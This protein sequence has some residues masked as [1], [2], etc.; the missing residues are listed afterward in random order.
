M[1][2]NCKLS[3]DWQEDAHSL[4]RETRDVPVINMFYPTVSRSVNPLS[5][6]EFFLLSNRPFLLFC[7]E[8]FLVFSFN[9]WNI[10]GDPSACYSN[11]S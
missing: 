9:F 7:I 6:S 5:N 8:N 10:L 4:S 11:H 1:P 3:F 2:R